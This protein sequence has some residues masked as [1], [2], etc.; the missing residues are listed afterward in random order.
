MTKIFVR[1][2]KELVEIGDL[3]KKLATSKK[4]PYKHAFSY[5]FNE[6]YCSGMAFVEDMIGTKP[7]YQLATKNHFIQRLLEEKDATD[8]KSVKPSGG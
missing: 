7:V 3:A 2:N 6:A 8:V 4:M 5:I 1:D